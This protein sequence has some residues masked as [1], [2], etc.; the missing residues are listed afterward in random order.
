MIQTLRSIKITDETGTNYTDLFADIDLDT[1]EL[2][3]TSEII[4][5]IDLTIP[6]DAHSP[7]ANQDGPLG[8]VIV[9]WIQARV[10]HPTDK[11]GWQYLDAADAHTIAFVDEAGE[12]DFINLFGQVE[13]GKRGYRLRAIADALG[14]LVEFT[15]H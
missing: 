2:I 1:V 12:I 9:R 13:H 8:A 3:G 11:Y 14:L 10:D 4:R 5:A 7:R 6:N 15:L